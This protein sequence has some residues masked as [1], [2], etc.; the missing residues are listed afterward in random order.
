MIERQAGRS[1]A[2]RDEELTGPRTG[3]SEKIYPGRTELRRNANPAISYHLCVLK[4][5]G[6]EAMALLRAQLTKEKVRVTF[7]FSDMWRNTNIQITSDT[8]YEVLLALA[9]CRRML[10]MGVLENERVSAGLQQALKPEDWEP[11]G[12]QGLGEEY[13]RGVAEQIRSA[14][15]V[16]NRTASLLEA[17]EKEAAARDVF[18][19]EVVECCEN[20][21]VDEHSLAEGSTSC[22]GYCWAFANF[23]RTELRGRMLNGLGC[24]QR[25]F[26]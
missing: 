5:P 7:A 19:R 26:V 4:C 23:F 8:Y 17:E 1:P 10:H 22:V 25:G 21:L 24:H 14:Q 3:L 2:L 18:L 12:W 6:Q 9:K 20:Y 16:Q 15:S 11:T 13:G